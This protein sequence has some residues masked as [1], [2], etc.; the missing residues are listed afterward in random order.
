MKNNIQNLMEESNVDG[1]LITGAGQHNPPMV[2]LTGGG[3]LTNSDL[4]IKKRSKT[5]SFSRIDGKR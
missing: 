5:N 4:I 3:H 2:Y 1:I